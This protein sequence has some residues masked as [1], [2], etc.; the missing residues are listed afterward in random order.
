MRI[1]K[2]LIV[3]FAAFCSFLP[4]LISAQVDTAWVRL[5]DYTPAHNVD[6]ANALAIDNTGNIYVTGISA[7]TGNNHLDYATIK[8][9]SIGDTVWVRRCHGYNINI[10]NWAVAVK[11][12][13]SNNVYVT[14]KSS[15]AGGVCFKTVK[16]NSTGVEQWQANH[17]GEMPTALFVD[18]SGNAYVT[19]Y[20]NSSGNRNYLTIKYNTSGIEQWTETYNGTASSAQDYAQSI[21]VDSSGNTYVTGWSQGNTTDYDYTTIKYNSAGDTLWVRRYNGPANSSDY[22]NALT[23]DNAGNIYIT[24]RSVDANYDIATVKYNSSGQQQWVVRYNG[25][26]NWNDC[27]NAIVVDSSGNIYVTGYS[28]GTGSTNNRDIITIKYNSTGIEQWVQRYNGYATSNDEPSGIAIDNSSNVYVTGYTT[29][30]S[31]YRDYI[32]LKYN[33]AGAQQWVKIYNGPGNN[34]D[35]A[36]TIAVN[37]LGNVFVTGLTNNIGLNNYDYLTIKY[38]QMQGIEEERTTLDAIR[39]TLEVFPNPA[40]TFFTVRLPLTASR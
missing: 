30:S 2:L 10:D 16:Y 21:A 14:G 17:Q 9:N 23:L 13:N 40:K 33:S 25:T 12:D 32:T 29:G 3:A 11:L 4:V 24:G 35:V 37:N 38:V 8:Y 19:G 18:A 27:G 22:A 20:E 5:Y 39:N 7:D 1:Y 26:G 34:D 31:G 36:S 28:I 6:Q 15:D